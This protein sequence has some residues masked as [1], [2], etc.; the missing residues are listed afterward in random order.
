MAWPATALRR[1]L[2]VC[3]PRTARHGA[4]TPGFVRSLASAQVAP[5]TPL[6]RTT[7]N[8]AEQKRRQLEDATASLQRRSPRPARPHVSPHRKRKK[9]VKKSKQ[10]HLH[11]TDL[12]DLDRKG[13]TASF[14]SDDAAQ[15]GEAAGL[16]GGGPIAPLFE[17][18]VMRLVRRPIAE[19]P[20]QPSFFIRFGAPMT[21]EDLAYD[22]PSVFVESRNLI[23]SVLERRRLAQSAPDY[24]APDTPFWR[25][26]PNLRAKRKALKWQEEEEGEDGAGSSGTGS[27]RD[28]AGRTISTSLA[29]TKQPADAVEAA[30][31]LRGIVDLKTLSRRW[32]TN[33]VAPVRCASQVVALEAEGGEAE[34]GTVRRITD[35]GGDPHGSG[36]GATASRRASPGESLV[37]SLRQRAEN[38]ARTGVDPDIRESLEEALSHHP[39]TERA[40]RLREMHSCLKDFEALVMEG[41]ASVANCNELIRAQ[42]LQGRMD[43]A[44]QTHDTMKLHGYEPDDETFVSLLIGAAKLRDAELARR[45]YLKMREQLIS[46][47]PKV[48]AALIKAHVRAGDLASGVSLLHKME[49]ERLKPDVVVHTVIIDGFVA[50]GKLEKAWE[51]FHSVRTWKLIQPDEVLFTVM[52][53]A[54]AKACEAERALNMLDDLRTTGLYPTDLTYGELIH[55]MATCPDHAHK[56][57]D[58]FRQMQ[59]EDM[60]LN[61]FIFGKLL[62]ACRSLTDVRKARQVVQDMHRHEIDLTPPMYYDLVGL[63]AAAMRRPRITENERFQNLR[64]AWHV[65]AEARRRCRKLDWTRMLNE[66]MGVYIAA[67]LAQFAVDML[68]QFAVFQARPDTET[69]R[70]LL[71]MLGRDL[72]DIGRFFALWDALP[73]EP[74]PSTALMHLALE[75]AMES[76]SARRTCTVLEEMYAAEVYPSPQLTDRL[77][78]VGRRVIQIHLLV[79]KFI[80]LNR[81]SKAAAA[82][83]E[84]ALLQAHMD[85]REVELA[86]LGQTTR[87]PTPQQQAREKHFDS[88]RKRGW[89]RRPWLPFAEYLASK[90][91]GGEAYRK[92]HELRPNL[93]GGA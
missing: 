38:F 83:R 84:T 46:A 32:Q 27:F 76:R 90:Q 79:G 70:Q 5:A 50:E 45:L 59:V 51:E 69:Y 9:R 93:L 17:P 80:A 65:V 2:E 42:A 67:G 10:Q 24:V 68:E 41:S 87:M 13:G 85:E 91:K 44:M 61:P 48:Y 16:G 71:E 14:S 53:K 66:V 35:Q 74:P 43:L 7:R 88:L 55:A 1:L 40:Q 52:I 77:A 60:P 64:C 11:S 26:P 36:G 75:M 20:R 39:G 25:V 30:E 89:F 34:G 37:A 6:P 47:T 92:R 28:G 15:P 58:F 86:A 62:Q 31:H 81:D 4:D 19:L 33:Q 22:A 3:V 57:F 49:D 72:K 21:A 29:A 56:A 73:R 18:Q 82:Q 23:D 8:P 54:C 63:F 12:Q 78:K